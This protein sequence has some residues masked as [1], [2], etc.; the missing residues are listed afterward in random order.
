MQVNT[1]S[2]SVLQSYTHTHPCPPADSFR[3]AQIIQHRKAQ[4]DVHT[5]LTGLQTCTHKWHSCRSAHTK[6]LL[7]THGHIL[8]CPQT[9]LHARACTLVVFRPVHLLLSPGPHATVTHAK[10]ETTICFTCLDLHSCGPL[11]CPEDNNDCLQMAGITGEC[12]WGQKWGLGHSKTY[13]HS[14][15]LLPSS[16]HCSLFLGIQDR[17]WVAV[18]GVSLKSTAIVKLLLNNKLAR[19]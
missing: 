8:M 14:P 11:P 6:A 19:T 12:P 9:Q 1:Y 2:H 3:N 15:T 4:P 18:E 16:S 5:D 13:P 7:R 10:A 17:G